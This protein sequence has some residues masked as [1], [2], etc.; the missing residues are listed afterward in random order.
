MDLRYF[1][2]K[3]IRKIFLCAAVNNCVFEKPVKVD[4]LASIS[5]TTI[6]KYSYIGNG[7][8]ISHAQVGR[9]CSISA[10]CAIGGGAHPLSWVS[11]SP[12]FNKNRNIFGKSFSDIPYN[13]YETVV[14]ENDVWIGGNC[15]I[16]S[17]VHIA[18]GAVIGMGSVVTKDVGP[19]EVWAGNPAKRI[20]KRFDDTTIERLLASKWWN[21][22]EADLGKL[23]SRF[24]NV[25]SF[26]DTVEKI[27]D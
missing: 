4:Y 20:K 7:T 8:S 19:Y 16:K 5:H 21:L 15:C 6:G 12:V 18:N 14:I 23:A 10:N 24:Q 25:E 2:S 11:T 13:P 9:F 26:L 27:S 22:Q 17:G 1:I 3:G